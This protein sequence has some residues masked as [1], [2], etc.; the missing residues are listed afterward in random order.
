VPETRFYIRLI[1][2]RDAEAAG[3][4][5][6]FNALSVR[7]ADA[8]PDVTAHEPYDKLGLYSESVWS[9]VDASVHSLL[10]LYEAVTAVSPNGWTKD[11]PNRDET[12]HEAVWDDRRANEPL[13]DAAV[14]WAH[15]IVVEEGT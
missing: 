1:T 10:A 2:R 3:A 15:V 9:R 7:I 11:E 14:S 5:A 4:L 8:V 12:L 13:F 6:S